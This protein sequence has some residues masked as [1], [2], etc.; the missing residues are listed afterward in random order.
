MNNSNAVDRAFWVCGAVTALSAIVSA[1]FSVAALLAPGQTDVNAMYAASRSIA[2]PLVVLAVTYFRSRDGL[3]AMALTMGLVQLLDAVIGILS[4]DPFKTWGPLG[5]ALITFA[6]RTW[7][8]RTSRDAR[9]SRRI[10][11][12]RP[13]Q[14]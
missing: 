14:S 7:L 4:H 9:I 1:S 5:I 8:M 3:A 2:L 13:E 11:Q 6:S 12:D 10:P